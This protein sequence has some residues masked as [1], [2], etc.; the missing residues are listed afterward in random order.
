MHY[1]GDRSCNCEPKLDLGIEYFSSFGNKFF[2]IDQKLNPDHYKYKIV[3]IFKSSDGYSREDATKLECE[4]H[5]KFSVKDSKHFINRAN[6][7]T[8]K[9]SHGKHTESSKQKMSRSHL[10]VSK[11]E[12]TKKKMSNSKKASP[13]NHKGRL[14]PMFG[15]KFDEEQKE[16]LS[17]MKKGK[18]LGRQRQVECPNCGKFGGVSS[19]TRYHF[20]NCKTNKIY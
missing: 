13:N 8:S 16:E 20:E 19:M 15:Y 17:K 9:F 5:E 18:K 11:T 2:E 14:N 4:F 7:T 12:I 6:Q 3:K 10:G 1:Y